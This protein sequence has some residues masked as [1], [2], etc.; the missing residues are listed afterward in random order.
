MRARLILRSAIIHDRRI[1]I[2][3]TKSVALTAKRA[4]LATA[5]RAT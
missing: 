1:G 3:L 4:R 2:D 5:A